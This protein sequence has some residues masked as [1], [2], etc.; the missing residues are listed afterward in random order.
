MWTGAYGCKWVWMGFYWCGGVQGHESTAKQGKQGAFRG[1]KDM[2]W[3]QWPGKF[4]RTSCF[5]KKNQNRWGRL[6]MGANAFAWVQWGVFALRDRKTRGNEAKPNGQCMFCRCDTTR[7]HHE[8]EHNTST[9]RVRAQHEHITSTSS[10]RAHHEHELNASTPRD[11]RNVRKQQTQ[12]QREHT[13]N[14]STTWAHDKHKHNASTEQTRAQREYTTGTSTNNASTRQ[15]RA[16][17]EHT[18]TTSAT[19]E[20]H[21][22]TTT[23]TSA[24]TQREHITITSTTRVRTQREQEPTANTSSPGAHVTSTTRTELVHTRRP[25]HA[26]TAHTYN[27]HKRNIWTNKQQ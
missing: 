1:P 16:Q 24:R 12:A 7:A 8:H 5:T 9:S 13:T 11:E 25:S 15:V 17:R 2:I 3:T 26:P 23:T 22:T 4:P 18:T 10:T 27:M 20:H 19:P 6:R 21:D 14:T